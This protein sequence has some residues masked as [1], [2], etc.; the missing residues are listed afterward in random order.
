MH[1][2]V[3]YSIVAFDRL[4]HIMIL[5]YSTRAH[6]ESLNCSSRDGQARESISALPAVANPQRPPPAVVAL[7]VRTQV[8]ELTGSSLG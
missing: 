5:G 7:V 3:A 4:L 1:V 2:H 6:L 8:L